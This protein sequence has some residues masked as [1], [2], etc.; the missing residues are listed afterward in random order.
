MYFLKIETYSCFLTT[1]TPLYGR[2]HI[3]KSIIYKLAA[4]IQIFQLDSEA[5]EAV[6]S[7]ALSKTG[8]VALR[9][10]FWKLYTS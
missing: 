1:D 5:E 6:L 2:E 9:P 8:F 10:I 4:E 7:L 3:L